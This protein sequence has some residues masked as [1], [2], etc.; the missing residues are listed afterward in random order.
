MEMPFLTDTAADSQNGK[1]GRNLGQIN[2]ISEEGTLTSTQEL[3]RLMRW[4]VANG[5]GY[6]D[7]YH[8]IAFMA[9]GT[10]EAPGTAGEKA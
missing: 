10:D 1:E 4:F 8:C 6:A 7:A 9:W 5:Y 2:V 3:E